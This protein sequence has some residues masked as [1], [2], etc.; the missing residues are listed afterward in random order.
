MVAI[1]TSL[2]CRVSAISAFCQP[3]T[4]TPSIT[5]SLVAII[6]TKPV[7]TI[8]CCG[9]DPQRYTRSRLCL[10]RIAWSRKPTPRIKLRVA[11]NHAVHRK[12]KMVAMATSL[13]TP[14]PSSDRWF[15]GLI[16]A[17]NPNGILIVSAVFAQMTADCP[18]TLQWNAPFPSKL[19]LSM[20]RSGPLSHTWYLGPR[21]PSTQT[22]SLS[23]SLMWQVDRQTDRPHHSV[24]NN[25]PHLCM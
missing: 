18:Y 21:E 22:A 15:L 16:R 2:R 19:P 14:R 24:G 17:H 23:G 4:Q 8:C 1:A 10:R 5:N 3:T 12:P 13:S 9:N 25:R 20:G 7:I 11:S 6:H